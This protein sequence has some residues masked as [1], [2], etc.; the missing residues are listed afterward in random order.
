MSPS[1]S[2]SLRDGGQGS[3]AAAA[4]K[5]KD[6]FKD[7]EKPAKR[8]KCALAFLESVTV[9]EQAQFIAQNRDSLFH[10]VMGRF[11]ELESAPKKD[12]KKQLNEL[13]SVLKVVRHFLVHLP[14][15]VRKRWQM[16]KFHL[17]IE[18]VLHRLNIRVL[19]LAGFEL[20][21]LFIEALGTGFEDQ[22]ALFASAISIEA[23]SVT[24]SAAAPSATPPT[25]SG[26]FSAR[27][28]SE[29]PPASDSEV[30]CRSV[31]PVSRRDVVEM[32]DFLFDFMVDNPQFEFW[33]NCWKLYYFTPLYSCAPS[34][35]ERGGGGGGSG[36]GR[37]GEADASKG[38]DPGAAAADRRF[39]SGCPVDLQVCFIRRMVRWCDR[40]EY[41][42]LLWSPTHSRMLLE[43]HCSGC[44][45]PM[46]Q[47]AAVLEMHQMFRRVLLSPASRVVADLGDKMQHIMQMI[48]QL[49]ASFSTST[50]GEE[51]PPHVRLCN[52]VLATFEYISSD[53]SSVVSA[54]VIVQLQWSTLAI[55]RALY[56]DTAPTGGDS[57]AFLVSESFCAQTLL[58]W[59]RSTVT[60][61]EMWDELGT[62]LRASARWKP[63]MLQWKERF[64]Q[65][66]ALLADVYILEPAAAGAT[67]DVDASANGGGVR[68]G[69]SGQRAVPQSLLKAPEELVLPRE[70]R[71][72]ALQ[73]NR[74]RTFDMWRIVFGLVGSVSGFTDAS[75][76]AV[77]A[78]GYL[79]AVQYLIQVIAARLSFYVVPPL[80]LNALFGPTLCEL[81]VRP[82]S[83]LV[84]KTTA[85]TALCL[86]FCRRTYQQP[87][88]GIL[89]HFYAV[90][91]R[92]LSGTNMTVL[93]TAVVGSC[94]IFSLALPGCTSLVPAYLLTLERML[95]PK[96]QLAPG[97]QEALLRLLLGMVSF[98]SFYGSVEVAE[99]KADDF[100]A[101]LLL[102]LLRAIQ[103]PFLTNRARET[104]LRL[105]AVISFLELRGVRR[106]QIIVE[107]VRALVSNL[108]HTDAEVARTAAQSL[109]L[110]A[111][112]PLATVDA[113]VVRF[114][115]ET[116]ADNVLALIAAGR[117]GV[118]REVLV[119]QHFQ[120]MFQYAERLSHSGVV[121]PVA[122]LTKLFRATE[123]G[124]LGEELPQA[125]A[126]R[127]PNEAEAALLVRGAT[128]AFMQIYAQLNGH[129]SHRSEIV[130]DAA[131]SFYVRMLNILNAFPSAAGSVVANSRDPSADS[132]GVGAGA[133]VQAPPVLR[134]DSLFFSLHNSVLLC[135][136]ELE[137]APD[138]EARVRLTA[139]GA[140]GRFSWDFGLQ[141]VMSYPRAY[142]IPKPLQLQ[143]VRAYDANVHD[144]ARRR[145]VLL[146][147]QHQRRLQSSGGNFHR[148][149][150]QMP[151]STL[152]KGHVVDP[153]AEALNYITER[154]SNLTRQSVLE[155]AHSPAV[156][157][158]VV[159]V[160]R[161]EET[162]R[163]HVAHADSDL[164]DAPLEL[165]LLT[166]AHSAR[167]PFHYARLLLQQLGLL[168]PER[169]SPLVFLA[170]S[171]RLERSL[172]DLDRAPTR[173]LYKTGLIYVR[174]K[175][176]SQNDILS[177]FAASARYR[178]LV[179]GLGWMVDLTT[180]PGYLG[181]LDSMMLSAGQFAPYYCTAGFEMMYH[182]ITLMPTK[183]NDPQQI[184]K[185]KHV[186][187]DSVHIVWSENWRPYDPHTISSQFNDAHVVLYPLPSGLVSVHVFKKDGIPSFGPLEDGMVL[188]LNLLAPLVRLTALNANVAV[189]SV[190]RDFRSALT[191][192]IAM[193]RD[194]CLKHR[195]DKAFPDFSASFFCGHIDPRQLEH[196]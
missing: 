23:F 73:W 14:A 106:K 177:N 184:H 88:A 170:P 35:Q 13:M 150:G 158:M 22:L 110:L 55:L 122:V 181:G 62:L 138:S 89:S 27:L 191:T 30:I 46:S 190:S 18:K 3:S 166:P 156:Q 168:G 140:F 142:E 64:L 54:E 173:E 91:N 174:D 41:C 8:F 113:S 90:L 172:G 116:A 169:R 163:E 107:C 81:A 24:S 63:L 175:Q 179:D 72:A 109:E 84:A 130:R 114:V 112:E 9:D 129:P 182:D 77:V 96:V 5:L 185:K 49:T 127:L 101:K 87:S 137:Q 147:E 4:K 104:S 1:S 45:M 133:M 37:A 164:A 44:L 74:E 105:A 119:A 162:E 50:G 108:T 31:E 183:E 151:T 194:I 128:S 139:R 52:E 193:V 11:G 65:C 53:L 145:S 33:L 126:R 161:Q 15:L 118:L 131:E 160:R 134:P 76:L 59:L 120:L 34:A 17:I 187:N 97:A 60:T 100:A 157:E 153:L 2:M 61:P 102:C 66:T 171:G 141:Y 144:H 21:L 196:N 43:L 10:V 136:T 57:T 125:G 111:N 47:V 195:T 67:A 80:D 40:P 189:R 71:L 58:I 28:R 42:A 25:M 51:V 16:G 99:C 26:K 152:L 79:S 20:L 178:T 12:L 124:L 121:L 29:K 85:V 69:P 56:A 180:H 143:P 188:P 117:G 132:S 192:R 123:I 94:R 38:T 70:R 78:S 159:D 7:K 149:S 48:C 82:E 75:S 92:C 155:R 98:P 103:H 167:S 176:E 39:S 83:F 135:V 154:Y 86:L 186:G 19:R 36:R 146:Q 115:L 165:A 148:P 6:F 95:N 93:E 32:F 68:Q